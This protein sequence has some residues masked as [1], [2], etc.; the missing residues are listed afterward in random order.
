MVT[1]CFA[2][3]VKNQLRIITKPF[4]DLKEIDILTTISDVQREFY[5]YN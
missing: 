5:Y 1:K 2:I 3:N 4:Q